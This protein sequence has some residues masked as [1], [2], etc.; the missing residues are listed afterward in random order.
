M[1]DPRNRNILCP[2]QQ[3]DIV[4]DKPWAEYEYK[5]TKET[6]KGQLAIKGTIDLITQ[7]NDDTLEIIDWKTGRRLDWAT[8]EEKTQSKL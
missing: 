5:T 2:E 4:I 3:F 7:I 8:G 6:I 1:F